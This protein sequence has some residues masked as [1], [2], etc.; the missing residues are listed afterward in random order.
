MPFPL[1]P[2]AAGLAA[3]YM[4]KRLSSSGLDDLPALAGPRVRRRLEELR[5]RPL[6]PELA[7]PTPR[8]DVWGQRGYLSQ[9]RYQDRYKSLLLNGYATYGFVYH[10]QSVNDGEGPDVVASYA[11]LDARGDLQKR[12]LKESYD[13][14]HA[15]Y[16][17]GRGDMV[18]DMDAGLDQDKVIIILHDLASNGHVIYEALQAAPEEGKKP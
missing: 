6:P 18:I 4:L 15:A 9:P 1:L 5:A 14:M 11:W 8:P 12:R 13:G 7:G 17:V 2:L 10:Y 16:S 3:L